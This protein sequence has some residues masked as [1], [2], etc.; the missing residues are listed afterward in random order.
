MIDATTRTKGYLVASTQ[1]FSVPVIGAPRQTADWYRV[2]F[3]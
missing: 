2:T 1:K 3:E